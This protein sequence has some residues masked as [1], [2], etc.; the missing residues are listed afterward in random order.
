MIVDH[1]QQRDPFLLTNCNEDLGGNTSVRGVLNNISESLQS[2]LHHCSRS[3]CKRT[4]TSFELRSLPMLTCAAGEY[5]LQN[6]MRKLSKYLSTLHRG[7]CHCKDVNYL[8]SSESF[9]RL[10]NCIQFKLC[11]H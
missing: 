3:S 1:R 10:E 7:P 9:S 5:G 8:K 6:L 4:R 2:H 11:H